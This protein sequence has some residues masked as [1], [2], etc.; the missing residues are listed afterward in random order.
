MLTISGK[1][2][3]AMN[4]GIETSGDFDVV[5]NPVSCPSE[6]GSI[7]AVPPEEQAPAPTEAFLNS[8]TREINKED[9]GQMVDSQNH[10]LSRFEKTVEM[11]INFNVLSES[12]Y[13]PTHHE[14]KK[15][16]AL[17]TDMKKDLDGIFRRIRSL[18]QSLSKQYPEAFKA[19]QNDIR[20]SVIED[21]EEE[22]A[23]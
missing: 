4:P 17:L 15:H 18:K 9:V 12:R 10:M 14:F 22:E 8:L 19:S 2:A 20:N 13:T 23:S 16:T 5:M 6:D 1:L 11:L 3:R 7:T 21:D